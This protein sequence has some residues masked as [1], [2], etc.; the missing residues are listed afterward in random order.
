M[1]KLDSQIEPFEKKSVLKYTLEI[2]A[3]KSVNL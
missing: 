1:N 2:Y 3:A